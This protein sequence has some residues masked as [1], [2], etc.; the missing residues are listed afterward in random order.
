MRPWCSPRF[1]CRLNAKSIGLIRSDWRHR[2]F[3]HA[4]MVWFEVTDKSLYSRNVSLTLWWLHAVFKLLRR[5]FKSTITGMSD[6][7][8]LVVHISLLLTLWLRE[9]LSFHCRV[10]KFICGE[11]ADI[12]FPHTEVA[13]CEFLTLLIAGLWINPLS[14]IQRF[15]D[16]LRISLPHG[17]KLFH[18]LDFILDWASTNLRLQSINSCLLCSSVEVISSFT[19]IR[20]VYCLIKH[21]TCT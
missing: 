16:I 19:E 1:L 11:V 7:V 8:C 15:V 13:L 18:G 10:L 12:C 14:F 4:E 9:I 3:A 5:L 17:A 20:L 6:E 21:W 2:L